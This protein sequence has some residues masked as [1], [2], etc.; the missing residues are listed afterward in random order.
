MLWL[1]ARS[2]MA[3]GITTA[4]E[5]LL[6][7]GAASRPL[8]FH[9]RWLGFTT[10]ARPPQALSST[11]GAGLNLAISKFYS[12]SPSFLYKVYLINSVTKVTSIFS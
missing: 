10:S 9:R 7:A 4:T 5:R 1:K 12:F 3:L 2:L 11:T 8:L 6:Q